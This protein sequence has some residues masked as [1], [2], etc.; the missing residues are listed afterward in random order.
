MTFS[1]VTGANPTAT[2]QFNVSGSFTDAGFGGT[3]EAY[4]IGLLS[5]G[6]TCGTSSGSDPFGSAAA[7]LN[8][9][10]HSETLSLTIP[11]ANNSPTEIAVAL[12]AAANNSFNIATAN[13]YDPPQ[14]SLHLPSGVTYTSASGVFLTSPVPLPS[15]VWLLGSG[16]I[17]LLF[18]AR[19]HRPISQA[20]AKGLHGSA[21]L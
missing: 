6:S 12:G 5:V 2:L 10:N 14:L 16:M 20:G 7:V 9:S 4:R 19:R 1:G 21:E 3:C 15:A 8:A 11:L 13:L 18:I 17:G